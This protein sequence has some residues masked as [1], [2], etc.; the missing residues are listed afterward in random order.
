LVVVSSSSLAAPEAPL[1]HANPIFVRET[2]PVDMVPTRM[3]APY[4][5]RGRIAPIKILTSCHTHCQFCFETFQGYQ[6]GKVARFFQFLK[7]PILEES[8]QTPE[9][10]VLHRKSGV[11]S[12]FDD[13]FSQTGFDLPKIDAD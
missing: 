13:K 2:T 8:G 3:M 6:S 12:S 5:P 11:N 7:D 4:M 10:R 9:T 1:T